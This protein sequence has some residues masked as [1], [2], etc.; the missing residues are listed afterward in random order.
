MA[1]LGVFYKTFTEEIMPIPHK[2]FQK[3][4]EKGTISN[5]FYKAHIT[6]NQTR[7]L[8]KRESDR[9]MNIG[10]TIR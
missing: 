4:K 2:C 3:I 1:S 8:Q 10:V 9:V 6:Q 7:T 5:S